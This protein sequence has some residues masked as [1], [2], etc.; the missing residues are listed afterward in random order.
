MPAIV[1]LIVMLLTWAIAAVATFDETP[2]DGYDYEAEHTGM[3]PPRG[4]SQ[5]DK[6][7]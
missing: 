2:D 3:P 4:E 1:I 6:A 7:A 5:Q